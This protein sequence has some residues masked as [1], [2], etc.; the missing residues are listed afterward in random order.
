MFP[1]L[2]LISNGPS[3][4]DLSHN[5]SIPPSWRKRESIFSFVSSV[6]I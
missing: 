1:P 3:I 6:Y 4:S 5:A 2:Q